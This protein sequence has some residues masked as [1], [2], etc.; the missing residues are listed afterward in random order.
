MNLVYLE[1]DGRKA[2]QS[3]VIAHYIVDLPEIYLQLKRHQNAQQMRKWNE[4]RECTQAKIYRPSAVRCACFRDCVYTIVGY[5]ID[6]ADLLVQLCAIC[7]VKMVWRRQNYAMPAHA[8]ANKRPYRTRIPTTHVDAFGESSDGRLPV[9]P[10]PIACST[11]VFG[12]V[13]RCVRQLLVE[14]PPCAHFKRLHR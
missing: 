14:W 4:M 3:T 2:S 13:A 8:V 1:F 12:R 10:S 6:A 7:S 9:L 11:L 5:F